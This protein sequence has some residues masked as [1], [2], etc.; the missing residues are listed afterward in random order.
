MRGY[1]TTV[2]MSEHSPQVDP[3]SLAVHH[4]HTAIWVGTLVRVLLQLLTQTGWQVCYDWPKTTVEPSM[5]PVLGQCFQVPRLVLV[6][7]A[8]DIL[9]YMRA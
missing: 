2:M 4:S 5:E 8:P 6:R 3:P 9:V 7:V 1:S